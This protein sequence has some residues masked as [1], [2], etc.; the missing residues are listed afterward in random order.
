MAAKEYDD[1]LSAGEKVVIEIWDLQNIE[2]YEKSFAEIFELY[3][4]NFGTYI[5]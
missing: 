4:Q 2:D 5:K 3:N 1:A